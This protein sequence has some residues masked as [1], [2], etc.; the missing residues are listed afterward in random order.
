MENSNVWYITG[1]SKGIGRSL[2]HQLLSQGKK[3]AATSRNLAAFSDIENENFLPI[4][5]DLTNDTSIAISLEKTQKHFGRIDVIINN[6][7]YGIGGAIEELSEQEIADNFNVNFFAVVKVVQQ[8]LPYLRSQHSGHI[9]NIS[10][11]A[12]FAPGLGWSIYSAAKFA[13]TGLSESLANDLKP[14]GIRVTA[15]LPGWFRTNFAKPDSI[16]YSSKQIEDYH[17]LRTAHQKM[18][19]IDGKQLGNP[20]KVAQAFIQ[21]VQTEN[22]PPLLFLGSDAYQRAKDKNVQLLKEM[23]QWKELS[24]STN[25]E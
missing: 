23:E 3:V 24:S 14:L 22:P 25:F 6:A 10:S 15:V 21:L 17:F 19:D 7:G 13:V 12:G 2:V 4:E 8:A 11:I 1:A 9:I 5:V 18:N 20:D 16:A